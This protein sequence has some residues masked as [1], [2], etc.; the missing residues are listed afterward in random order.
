MIEKQKF[1]ATPMGNMPF[2]WE[3]Y[4]LSELSEFITKGATPTT[5]GFKWQDSGITFLRSEC[6]SELGYS[7]S[8]VA[9]IS[10]EA[11]DAMERSK[12]KGGDIL[13][14]ITGNVGRI[15]VYPLDKTE[16]NINQHIARVRIIKKEIA[17]REFIYYQLNQRNYRNYY[18]GIITGAAYP[19][20]SLKQ[21]RE[22]SVYL[23]PLKIQ[24]RIA[25]ILSAYDDLIENN[26]K[27]IKLLEQAAQ[28]IYTEWFVNLRFPGYEDTPINEETGLPEGWEYGVVSDL[29]EVKLGYAF[30]SKQWKKEGNPVIK[31]KNINNNTVSLN[32]TGFVDDEVAQNAK[33]YELFSGD[34][35]IAMTGATVGKVGL[36]PKINK[37]IYLNQRVGLFRPLS[38]ENNNIALVFSFFLTDDSQQQVLNFAQ[39]AAQPNISGSEIGN[40]KLNIADSKILSEFN[41]LTKPSIDSIQTLYGQNQKLKAARDILLP[42]LMNRTIEV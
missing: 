17:N 41:K 40:V 34:V 19:Q 25:D 30:K 35:I 22:T 23:P 27:R 38:D 6:V 37:R 42:R 29:C 10:K 13:I 24:K 31:I 4:T 33:K 11:H 3:K 7:E 32:D 15:A 36:I 20:L 8:G 39:G 9:F 1:I 5:Y 12:I 16:G 26:L 18:L 21:I 14:S 28:N 2:D